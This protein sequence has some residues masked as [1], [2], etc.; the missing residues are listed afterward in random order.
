MEDNKYRDPKNKDDIIVR[1]KN[2]PTLKEI[3]EL[4]NEV[5]PAWI[6]YFLDNY[7]PDY[8]HIQ[9]NWEF[10]MKKNNMKRGQI[11]I[12]DYFIDDSDHELLKIFT[13]IYTILGFMVRTKEE[14]KKCD[15]C[16]SALPTEKTFN[17]I[18]ESNDVKLRFDVWSP[19]CSTC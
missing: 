15:V 6:I 12:V 14:L 9:I 19:K 8:E 16:N 10:V 4:V 3:T 7:S 18:K 17:K 1:L 5:F 13:E 2:C 11:L